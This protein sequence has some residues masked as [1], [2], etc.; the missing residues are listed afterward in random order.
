MRFLFSSV[1]LAA[2]SIAF[3][4]SAA[5]A[6]A[7]KYPVAVFSG[8]DKTTARVTSFT[9]KVD[10]PASFGALQVLVRA[11]DKRPPE[12]PP[13]TAAYVEIRQIDREAQDAVKPAPIFAGWMFAESP[14]L[15]G[16]EHPVYDIWVTDCKTSSGDASRA[17]E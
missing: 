16:L 9:A 12:E 5:P 2:A 14:G 3:C 15:N 8:L 17:S 1:P 6:F 10:E 13:Q 11:C 4:L 7:D